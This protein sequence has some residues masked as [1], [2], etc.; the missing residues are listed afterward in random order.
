MKAAQQAHT[1]TPPPITGTPDASNVAHIFPNPKSG[2][3]F[4]VGQFCDYGC[5]ATF[6]KHTMCIT[7]NG[8]TVLTCNISSDT[9]IIWIMDT[10]SSPQMLQANTIVGT[11][12]STLNHD[13]TTNHVAFYHV[14]L[15]SPSLSTRCETIDTDHFMTRPGLTTAQVWMHP[16]PSV[17]MHKGH[18]D[19][20]CA[21]QHSTQPSPAV[22]P[23]D[24]TTEAQEAHVD[25]FPPEPSVS[26]SHD[27][28]TYCQSTTCMV[29]RDPT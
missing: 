18:L 13:T 19:H 22:I 4:T 23:T 11:V 20:Q 16:P 25:T 24:G 3:L 29:C 2:S 9:G 6:K 12:G 1:P 26:R 5:E 10:M 8:N 28:Y 27:I 21:N 7:A 17:A 15:F 14:S